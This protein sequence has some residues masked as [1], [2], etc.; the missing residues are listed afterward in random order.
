MPK[1]ASPITFGR[2]NRGKKTPLTGYFAPKASGSPLKSSGEK[3][4]NEIS[5]GGGTAGLEEPA[6]TIG[7]GKKGKVW[8]RPQDLF[9]PEW[10]PPDSFE[11]TTAGGEAIETEPLVSRVSEES[12]RE[13]VM[14]ETLDEAAIAAQLVS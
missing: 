12:F 2:K 3:A 8:W 13:Q 7:L 11:G 10:N 1:S 5:G 6:S 14:V 9:D 4:P